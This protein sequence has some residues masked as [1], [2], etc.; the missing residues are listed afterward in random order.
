MIANGEG[1]DRPG[2]RKQKGLAATRNP[3]LSKRRLAELVEEATIDAYGESE[4]ATG[5][6][7][8]MENDL[9]LPFATEVLGVA[10]TVESIDFDGDDQLVA[11][12]RKGNRRQRI[13]LADLPMPSPLPEGA[14]WIAAYCHWRRGWK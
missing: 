4:Q 3:S 14:E 12:C 11:V 1:M 9:R 5:F 6:Y 10:V 8:M 7:T 2:G 13:S